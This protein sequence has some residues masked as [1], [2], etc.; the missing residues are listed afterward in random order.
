MKEVYPLGDLMREGYAEACSDPILVWDTAY[1]KG[2]SLSGIPPGC[3]EAHLAAA[4]SE[5]RISGRTTFEETKKRFGE[6]VI[7]QAGYTCADAHK[8]VIGLFDDFNL[9]SH[10]E[11][12]SAEYER[13]VKNFS[14]LLVHL[15]LLCPSQPVWH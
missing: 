13:A 14:R 5:L 10:T 12:E 2:R 1:D 8:A 15:L 4:I 7:R 3:D 11:T 9:D 6:R